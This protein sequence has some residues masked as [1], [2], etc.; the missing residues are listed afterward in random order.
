M[1]VIMETIIIISVIAITL[2]IAY[3][4]DRKRT[5]ITKEFVLKFLNEELEKYVEQILQADDL[6][7]LKELQGRLDFIKYTIQKV[8]ELPKNVKIGIQII[9]SDNEN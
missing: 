5:R 1:E 9:R 6:E 3:L 8:N 2:S 7:K 4:D